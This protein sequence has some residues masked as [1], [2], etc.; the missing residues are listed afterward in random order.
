MEINNCEVKNH[1]KKMMRIY[2]NMSR[3]TFIMM[4]H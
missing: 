3:K 1:E 4:G 2:L